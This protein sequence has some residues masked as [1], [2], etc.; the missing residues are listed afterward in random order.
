VRIGDDPDS[1]WDP[2]ESDGSLPLA[3]LFGS[4]PVRATHVDDKT[5]SFAVRQESRIITVW[6]RPPSERRFLGHPLRAMGVDHR[7]GLWQLYFNF[8]TGD[9]EVG[10]LDHENWDKASGELSSLASMPPDDEH[11]DSRE[12]MSRICAGAFTR[13]QPWYATAWSQ[14]ARMQEN[15]LSRKETTA[16]AEELSK[17]R[18]HAIGVMAMIVSEL[19]KVLRHEGASSW[20]P[21]CGESCLSRRCG[22]E[23]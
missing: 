2:P 1:P 11:G 7:S 8:Q 12:S 22:I 10:R 9:R 5:Y 18:A 17:A 15:S 19:D 21:L 4:E 14:V 3:A 6:K 13:R 20:I 16:S 23:I